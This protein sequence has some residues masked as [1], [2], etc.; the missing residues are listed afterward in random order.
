MNGCTIIRGLLFL[1]LICVTFPPTI[2]VWSQDEANARKEPLSTASNANSEKKATVEPAK[3]AN[4][5]S[6]Q[7]AMQRANTK[8]I[9]LP[10]ELANG[11][12]IR[13]IGLYHSQL[14]ELVPA[15]FQ[16]ISIEALCEA[17]ES[18]KRRVAD[19]SIV[20]IRQSVY[21]VELI[22]D[23][24]VSSRS[25][26]EIQS[27]S[28]SA[29]VCPL[30]DV[31]LA[32]TPNSLSSALRSFDS[33]KTQ[34]SG[35]GNAQDETLESDVAMDSVPRLQTMVDGKL[36]AV[37]RGDQ[38]ISFGWTLQSESKGTLKQ[39]DLRL[40]A[41]PQT[42]MVIKVPS[43]V[44]IESQDGVVKRSTSPPPEF[45]ESSRSPDSRYFVID[46][47]GLSRV[48][49]RA[50]VLPAPLTENDGDVT[51]FRST[52]L[53]VRN[54]YAE[55]E[56]DPS[57]LSWTYRVGMQLSRGMA[58]PPL[59]VT[60]SKV[61]SVHVNSVATPFSLTALNDRTTRIE[62]QG[63]YDTTL[64]SKSPTSIT[65]TGQTLWSETNGWTDLPIPYFETPRI[66]SSEVN[67]RVQLTTIRPLRLLEWELPFGWDIESENA[68]SE[69][70]RTFVASGS[71]TALQL[72]TDDRDRLNQEAKGDDDS[73][74][75][76]KQSLMPHPWA[77]FR[78]AKDSSLQD[79]ATWL[80][81]KV[82]ESTIQ[83]D[84]RLSVRIDP[85][86]ME[87][88]RLK[89]QDG[90]TLEKLSFPASQRVIEP[91]TI[92]SMKE[93]FWIWPQ[94]N[95]V[96]DSLLVIEATGQKIAPKEQ[97]HPRT[98]SP[99]WFC[100]FM[101]I[102]SDFVAAITPPSNLD[103]SSQMF[104]LKEKV[105][106][107]T[108]SKEMQTFFG[109]FAPSTFLV[110]TVSARTPLLVLQEPNIALDVTT[111]YVIRCEN[112]EMIEDLIV[113][114]AS[115][116]Q[117]P[118]HLVI[119]LGPST[120]RPSMSWTLLDNG[121]EPPIRLSDA[122]VVLRNAET[123]GVYDVDVSRFNL[124]GKRLVGH[125]RFPF[126]KVKQNNDKMID[127]ATGHALTTQL[128]VVIGATSHDAEVLV[129]LGLT[130]GELSESVLRVPIDHPFGV[131]DRWESIFSF[132]PRNL[133]NQ[134]SG[135]Q[136]LS[137]DENS[138]GQNA[139]HRKRI[140]D[141]SLSP[142]RIVS[143]LQYNAVESLSI[144]VSK[145]ESANEAN[146][147]WRQDVNMIASSHG[148]D[149]IEAVLKVSAMGPIEIRYPPEMQLI[150]LIRN[151]EKI[152]IVNR[153]INPIRLAPL[154]VDSG[155]SPVETIRLIW[156]RQ[157]FS[158]RWW[159]SC[160]V[161]KIDVSG[162]V[163]DQ[164]F[165]VR[166][167]SDS[168]LPR[169][170]AARNDGGKFVSVD[171][172]Q[173]VWLVRRNN[174]LA[175]GWLLAISLF[176]AHWWLARL[177]LVF[178]LIFLSLTALL[179]FLWW[180]WHPVLIG[181]IM[182]PSATASL[183][184]ATVKWN[185]R[186]LDLSGWA[187]HAT[188]DGEQTA[189]IKKGRI[190]KDDSFDFSTGS[191]PSVVFI[192]LIVNLFSNP[193]SAQNSPPL[194]VFTN[195]T[196]SSALPELP[197]NKVVEVLVPVDAAGKIKGN[198]V[199]LPGRVK[200]EL[201]AA[202]NS[203]LPEDARFESANYR[204]R[205]APSDGSSRTNLP[206][207]DAEFVLHTDRATDRVEIPISPTMIRR[208][209]WSQIDQNRIVQ[210]DA[211][212]ANSIVAR[213]PTGK[214]F[215]LKM[216]LI[217]KWVSSESKSRLTI[218]IPRIVASKLTIE[219]GGDIQR[220]RIDDAIGQVVAERELQLWTA[221]IGPIGRLSVAIDFVGEKSGV[222]EKRI[223]RRYW[224]HC[225]EQRTTVECQLEQTQNVIADDTVSV[226]IRDALLPTLANPSWKIDQSEL[227]SPT[228]RQVTFRSTIDN[229]GPI[230]LLWSLSSRLSTQE[231]IDDAIAMVIPDVVPAWVDQP[232]PAWIGINAESKIRVLPMTRQPLEALTDDQF[233]A[234]WSGYRGNKPDRTFIAVG[235]LPNFYLIANQSKTNT[236]NQSHTI[237]VSGDQI[238]VEYRAV[239]SERDPAASSVVLKMPS[240]LSLAALTING[241]EQSPN[242][243]LSPKC[244]ELVIDHEKQLPQTVITASATVALNKSR[245]SLPRLSISDTGQ[246]IDTYSITRDAS[247]YLKLIKP[248]SSKMTQLELNRE[249]EDLARG[250]VPFIKFSYDS[251]A[252]ENTFGNPLRVPS[253]E[254]NARSKSRSFAVDQLVVLS[255]VSQQWRMQTVIKFPKGS[256]PDYVDIEIPTRW[257][258][259]LEVAPV[260]KWLRQPVGD[261]STQLIRIACDEQIRETRTL[262]ISGTLTA[263]DK[264]RVSAPTIAVLGEG[265]RNVAVSVPEKLTNEPI[266][267][268]PVS[269]RSSKPSPIWAGVQSELGLTETLSHFKVIGHPWSVELAPMRQKNIT[270]S[271][272][273]ADTRIY[274]R[275]DRLTVVSHFDLVPGSRDAVTLRFPS[276]AKVVSVMSANQSVPF[277]VI[278]DDSN[279]SEST[280]R[281]Q[282]NRNISNGT[283]IRLPLALS[284]LPQSIDIVFEVSP[285]EGRRG[286]YVPT[287]ESMQVRE[288]WVSIYQPELPNEPAGLEMNKSLVAG[289]TVAQ[290]SFWLATASTV[291]IDRA[292]DL[293][294]E[295]PTAEGKAWLQT[296]LA[297]YNQLMVEA[298]RTPVTNV[299][300]PQA[301]DGTVGLSETQS[302][303]FTIASTHESD[304]AGL[305]TWD[306]LD[307][308]IRGRMKR[309]RTDNDNRFLLMNPLNLGTYQLRA[310]YTLDEDDP[311]PAISMV[312]HRETNLHQWIVN[313]ITLF[314]GLVVAVLM[315]PLRRA[316]DPVVAHPAFW[317]GV[318]AVLGFYVAPLP[319][320]AAL[321]LVAI[322]LPAFPIRSNG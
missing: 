93:P 161:P 262:M 232:E 290:R 273:A 124:R 213:V 264:S 288:H 42:R 17:V 47:G 185:N 211:I 216:T 164:R 134:F 187:D 150:Q 34:S 268:R 28:K 215:R 85:T 200:A 2:S 106:A 84:V 259:S 59:L 195:S 269:V 122:D 313:L 301:F 149:R 172:G 108:L 69:E 297:R 27:D 11:S 233:L 190:G 90:W 266:R 196:K 95:D 5:E 123:E 291:L 205:I 1:L 73:G 272:L 88:I 176:A 54:T 295:R 267:W 179:T 180:P 49:L 103:W 133:E 206:L 309:Y 46:A 157:K 322:S 231:S 296:I 307:N 101:D 107:N 80:K 320:A 58:I 99:T 97:K 270:A 74:D 20:R 153:D 71:T 92:G 78:I 100:R 182:I 83:A 140:S 240:N 129:G 26:I 312:G 222:Q 281:Q 3:L 248:L 52:P 319:V 237:N 9:D 51:S 181:W 245:F 303:E 156:N 255:R 183:L 146:F 243:V 40:P 171:A 125:R 142:M 210:F 131:G 96:S 177:S 68:I 198:K 241:T 189:R 280:G 226:F 197:A 136:E 166:A 43:Q 160:E 76:A 25:E 67:S 184:A 4:Q 228:R 91:A 294:A 234:S 126:E 285:L 193:A 192:W 12:V 53:L 173:L 227:L 203:L 116:N 251:S 283:R 154:I 139:S 63:S 292:N 225:G 168:F 263:A 275:S 212:S 279:P 127:V 151:H 38:T 57:V 18:R 16:P 33:F 35:L 8:S 256:L 137:V 191:L 257:C 39:F 278:P 10:T 239:I 217:P 305:G 238:E 220:V 252:F 250:R 19:A 208:I 199:Y 159:R 86:R 70:K 81:M 302:R 318:I 258:D 130:V 61:V 148:T 247:T 253:V 207:I 117:S 221:D 287:I 306:D 31:N 167:S 201:L 293:L 147:I 223:L 249:F 135:T 274:P 246:T 230:Q 276:E 229:A 6:R 170:L 152:D 45:D 235:Q 236:V 316:I 87:P 314:C 218:D 66:I 104:L 186:S 15:N 115:V 50:K 308:A 109:R 286:N 289:Q 271:I 82:N 299:S 62:I 98:I 144:T 102:S 114:T 315:W 300:Q 23:S 282:Q 128:P 224:M 55:Y 77:R 118:E 29:T 79:A 138:F 113:E 94:P 178:S 112:D 188:S 209:E 277:S 13:P 304:L 175:L 30:G 155:D 132:S 14:A 254:F 32:I 145:N 21:V 37:V 72:N 89:L 311:S 310:I 24:L 22:G 162:I 36:A 75:P 284:R 260:S 214:S 64:T 7:E 244:Y 120:K 165:S 219:G 163:L 158:R 143:R 202:G 44:E 265:P 111:A 317:L 242:P 194:P 298:G 105:E 121:S 119:A 321:L 174:A 60:G 110:R 204:L 169:S 56:I 48:R 65:I 41:A 261:L 141:L